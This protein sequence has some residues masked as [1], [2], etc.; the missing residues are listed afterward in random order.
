MTDENGHDNESQ[1]HNLSGKELAIGIQY[2]ARVG[3]DRQLVM[4]AG[5]PA[6][7]TP[8]QINEYIDK[9]TYCIDRQNW[10]GQLEVVKSTLAQAQKEIIT[11]V[12]QL[13]S[14]RARM[15]EDWEKSNRR[16]PFRKTDAQ[17]KGDLTQVKNI[18]HLRE[19]RI[20]MLQR[21]IAELEAQIAG[22]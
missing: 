10:K 13:E 12:Q 1:L 8:L 20:P 15:V 17:E 9:M 19:E 7:L 11:N 14:S 22:G 18:A 16:G 6:S 21:Q 4:T 3:N 5:V 2:S